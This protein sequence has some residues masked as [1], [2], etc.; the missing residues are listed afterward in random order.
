MELILWQ[1][2]GVQDAWNNITVNN[3][4]S[5]TDDYLMSLLDDVFGI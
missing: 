2:R 5:L 1:L 3:S 4:K